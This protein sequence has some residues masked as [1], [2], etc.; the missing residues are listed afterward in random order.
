M[1][2]QAKEPVK[3]RYKKLK[4]G[5]TSLYLDIYSEGRR[6]YDFLHLY[7]TPEL[8]AK[9]RVK[10]QK[11]LA[12]ANTIKAQRI[13][14]L[15]NGAHGF[16]DKKTRTLLRFVDYLRAEA[17]RYR[18]KGSRMYAQSVINS[19]NHL[20]GYAGE[21]ITFKQVNKPFLLG[22]IN[23]LD[24]V[25][26]RGNKPLSGA[27]K[28]LYFQVVVTAL[29]RAVKEE[30]I[31][32]N[33][34]HSIMAEDRPEVTQRQRE[35]LTLEE[36]KKLIA[37]PCRYESIKRAFLFSCF[38]G[39]RLSDIRSLQWKD[40]CELSGGKMQ[41]RIVQQKTGEPIDV[42]LAGNA[43]AQLPERGKKTDHVF[44]LPMTWVVEEVLKEWTTAAGIDKR[45]TYH[46]SRHTHATMLLTYG[47]D[48]YTVS[49]LLGHTRVQTTEIYARIV[50][51]KKQEAVD[52]IPAVTD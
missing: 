39:L 45:V 10:N 40:I 25:T 23:Y 1:I 18:A 24:K 38:C 41:V 31:D 43:V 19:T 51:K 28:A 11:T 20:V 46:V 17:D 29:N 52:L 32:K 22:Y 35:F 27:S 7:L 33:P 44:V 15:Q 6:H 37:A 47:A 42:P 13:V 30:I 36:V 9:D 49:K 21:K 2:P 34:A 16:T 14:E 50:D 12:L 5:N 26:A 8:T 3:L 4:N 48:I